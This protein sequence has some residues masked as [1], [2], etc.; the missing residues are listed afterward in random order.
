[1]RH[2][3]LLALCCCVAASAVAPVAASGGAD[4]GVTLANISNDGPDTNGD[5]EVDIAI[6]PTNPRNLIAAWNDYG[7]GQSCGWLLVRRRQDVDDELAAWSHARRRQRTLRLRCRRPVRRL[8]QRRHRGPELRR[9]GRE[10]EPAE[11]RLRVAVDRRR[12]HVGAGAA[13]DLRPEPRSPAGPQHAHGRPLRQPGAGRVQRVERLPRTLLRARLLG[14]RPHVPGA[15]RDRRRLQGERRRPLRRLAGR[16]A[17]RDDLRHHRHLAARQRVERAGGRR[18]PAASRRD[19][20]HPQ[21]QGA[22]PRPGADDASRRELAHVD[23]SVDRRRGRRDRRP[24]DR[25]LRHRKPRHLPRQVD[26]PRN[27]LPCLAAGQPDERHG[28][29]GDAVAVAQ[30]RREDRPRL[31]RLRQGDRADERRLRTARGGLDALTARSC[32]RGSTATPSLRA[33]RTGRRSSATTSAST[34]PTGSSRSPGPATARRHR[35]SSR[36]R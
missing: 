34:R 1:M 32:S 30:P 23:A 28:R 11:R 27:E 5:N 8:P 9:V 19:E 17:G 22:R 26:R 29:P 12:P 33:A 6:N 2:L 16:R 36:P 31:L 15:V 4:E 25:G 20:V 35:T 21:R 7:P 18:Q 10:Q 24:S 13:A 3:W 14:R